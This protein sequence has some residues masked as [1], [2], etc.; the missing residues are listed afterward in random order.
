MFCCVDHQSSF[1]LTYLVS[2]CVCF[3]AE[4]KTVRLGR[5]IVA[6][7]YDI[8]GGLSG[9]RK[10]IMLI[11]KAPVS[12]TYLVLFCVCFLAELKMVQPTRKSGR[13]RERKEKSVT[14]S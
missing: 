1:P 12:L 13:G 14:P 11:I 3:L 8:N 4:L 6:A 5:G 2:F 9:R 7:G 10:K